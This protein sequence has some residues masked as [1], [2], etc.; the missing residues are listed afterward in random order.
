MRKFIF[1]LFIIMFVCSQS[2]F[3][4]NVDTFGIGSKATAM[5]GAFTAYADDPFAT[6]YNPAGLTQIDSMTFAAGTAMMDPNLKAKDYTVSQNH[7]NIMGPVDFEDESEDL[8]VPHLGFAMPLTD[9]VSMG[10]AVY[11][12]FGLHLMW[13]ETNDPVKNPAGYNSHESWYVRKVISPSIAYRVNDKLS[14]GFGVTIGQSESGSHYNSYTLYK[15]GITAAIEADL[16]DDLNYSWNA[17]VMYKPVKDLSIGLTYR[18]RAEADFEG[19][20]K[21]NKL[22]DAEKATL[23]LIGVTKY[24]YNAELKDVDHPEQ[25]QFGMRY[26]PSPKVSIEADLVWTH[27]SIVQQ[28]TLTITDPDAAIKALLNIE[29]DGPVSSAHARNWEDTR[30]IKVGLEYLINDTYTFR[31]GYFYDPSPIPDE[32]FDIVWSDADKKSYSV[33]LGANFGNWTVDGSFQ[34]VRTE[35][36]R[37]IGGESGNLN[38]SYSSPDDHATV[39]AVAEGKIYGYSMTVSYK[40]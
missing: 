33:G 8:I 31:C 30:Q 39:S 1:S 27:W 15:R 6:Y 2:A 36:D 29:G 17:G 25:V 13:D 11:V 22:S 40:F 7:V 10:V 5:G 18:G 12:P 26:S 3:A 24:E 38:H 19:S 4:N 20:L 35:M 32:T 14:L 23:G 28:Q 16:E 37:S 34:Y 9:S 21:L